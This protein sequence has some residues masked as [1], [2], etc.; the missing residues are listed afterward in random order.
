MG[1]SYLRQYA[2]D[3]ED[4]FVPR[5]YVTDDGYR[6]GRFV[7]AQR[8]EFDTDRRLVYD[9]RRRAAV[10]SHYRE[11]DC[12]ADRDERARRRET[13]HQPGDGSARG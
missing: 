12:A 6:L 13:V 4:S 2:L 3:N 10:V 9:E 8:D 7:A 11:R 1:L 5:S